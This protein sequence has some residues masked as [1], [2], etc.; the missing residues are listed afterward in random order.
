MKKIFLFACIFAATGSMVS[1]IDDDNNYNYENINEIKGG[2][3]NFNNMK[4]SYSVAVGQELT[5]SPTFEY[6]IDKENPDVTFEW[7]INAEK[8]EGATAQTHTFVFDKSGAYEVSFYV[9]D[10]KTGIK[11][12]RSATVTV[13]AEYQRGWVIL[14]KDENGKSVLNFITPSSMQYT[15]Q[16][17]GKD[18][19]RDSVIYTDCKRNLNPNLPT[20]PKKMFL[21]VGN[22]DY[23]GYY[24]VSVYDE[25]VIQGDQWEELDGN[26]LE[27]ASYTL[28]EFGDGQQPEGIKL[29]E[30]SFTFSMKALR[31]E[32]GY[33]YCNVKPDAADFHAGS[34]TPVP[35][36]NG[37]KFK[38]LFEYRKF[39]GPNDKTM[40]AL[41]ED[42]SLVA[43]CDGG[44]PMSF[45]QLSTI[46]ESSRVR[47][48]NV[49]D[50]TPSPST[51]PGL[52]FNKMKDEIVDVRQI[53][54]ASSSSGRDITTSIPSYIALSRDPKTNQCSL[55]SF[56]IDAPYNNMQKIVRVEEYYKRPFG[57]INNY[58]DMAVFY[59]KNYVIIAD[60]NKLY[61]CQY[62][63]NRDTKVEMLGERQLIKTFD[64]DIVS[65]DVQDIALYLKTAMY[66]YPGQLGVALENGEFF[67]FS[68]N[69]QKD[70]DGNCLKAT[71]NQLFPNEFVKDNKFGNIVD[72]LYKG[73]KSFGYFSFG[74]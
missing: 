61:Y 2:I 36:N 56:E 49:Y 22:C 42:N 74:F 64:S 50:L 9:I 6:T 59:F 30:G 16:Y 13:M 14:S 66:D 20:N 15:L 5:L 21:A 53:V 18:L 26:N 19:T 3:N 55:F 7:T 68:I 65:L 25:I 4:S 33:I 48:S 11:Y 37:M 45:R 72:V 43:I 39:D 60:G 1:C 62:G 40:I 57:T 35:I 58:K 10:N 44:V 38:R 24:G 71:M 23:Y 29:A 28:D 73:G 67:I 69:E 8:V 52:S 51:Y 63:K 32:N 70:E 41:T 27:H 47:S 54:K 12:G 31:D 17:N 46:N 34:Y